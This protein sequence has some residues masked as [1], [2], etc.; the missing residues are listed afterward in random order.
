MTFNTAEE[1]LEFRGK[2]VTDLYQNIC[3]VTF[4]K[5]DGQTRI[6]LC[7]NN[8]DFVPVVEK[9]TDKIRKTN[10]SVISAYDIN[11]SAY[12]SF[13]VE[14]ILDVN[15]VNPKDINKYVVKENAL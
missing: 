12:R 3:L 5:K 1:L 11:K 8:P 2:I 7:T 13:L 9:K 14:N 6:M 10:L 15:I 4:R